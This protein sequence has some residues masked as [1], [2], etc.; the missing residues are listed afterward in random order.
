M[1]F[2]LKAPYAPF[3]ENATLGILPKHLW[4]GVTA[5]EF[6]FSTLN[7]KP[8]GSGPYSIASV[9]QNSSGIPTEYD[10]NGFV[11]GV[12]PP[13]I[14]TVVFKFYAT[15]NALET[16]FNRGEVQ[17]AYG[18]PTDTVTAAHAIHEAIFGR[19]FAVFFNQ[20]QNPIF[21][22]SAV[23]E[24]LDVSVD[25]TA[26]VSTVLKGYGS[27]IAS[28]LPPDTVGISQNPESSKEDRVKAAQALLIKAGW[29][30]GT[31]GVF[32]KRITVNKK[33]Q[34]A[35]LQ[36]SLSTS[37]VPELK[38][39]AEIVAN[40]WK[41]IGADVSLK[42]FDQNDLTVDVLRPRTYDALL[43]GMVVGSELDLY[44]FWH[45]SQRNNPG[46]NVALYANANADK[47]LEAART[48]ADVL[49]RRE[50]AKA[51]AKIISGETAAVFLYTPHFVYLSPTGV[52]GV[53]LGTI[54]TPSDRFISVDQWYLATERLWP[55]FTMNWH[56][57]ITKIFTRT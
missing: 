29:K 53:I 25:K 57:F 13:Y 28:P 9:Q 14:S 19:V 3:L 49:A 23:R 5:E 55:L 10:L 12:R 16:A 20:N 21:A 56:D 32:E 30:I 47:I 2:T 44:P 34:T 40:S 51:A 35:R 26:I 24:A 38:S 45:S 43:F 50:K 27:V 31:D 39:A 22:E 15:D 37:N 33:K 48:E 11:N 54:E 46:L 8:V 52:Q 42:F 6:P 41:A 4:Q 17:A 1:S 7:Q 36:F 18:I